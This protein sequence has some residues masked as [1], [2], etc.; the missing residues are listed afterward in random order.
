MYKCS[1]QNACNYRLYDR[2]QAALSDGKIDM[3]H[4]SLTLKHRSDVTMFVQM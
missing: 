4:H 3:S 1:M 2:G